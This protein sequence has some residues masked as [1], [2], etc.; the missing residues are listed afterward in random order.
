MIFLFGTLISFATGRNILYILIKPNT[1]HIIYVYIIH[2]RIYYIQFQNLRVF[3]NYRHA[4]IYIAFGII[5]LQQ[6]HT[7]VYNILYSG[8][9]WRVPSPRRSLAIRHEGCACCEQYIPTEERDV[10]EYTINGREAEVDNPQASVQCWKGHRC[11]IL[12]YCV[13]IL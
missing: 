10:R 11:I 7:Y 12:S 1:Q 6:Q 9:F 3:Q 13:H 4:V 2:T 8:S 5:L